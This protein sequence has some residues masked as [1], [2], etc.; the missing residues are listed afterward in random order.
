MRAAA[1][2]PAHRQADRQADLR[3]RRL[4]DESDRL[5][6]EVELLRLG[7]QRALPLPLRA[8]IERFQVRLG[9]SD[10]PL[11]PGSLRSAHEVVLALQQRLL[12]ANPRNPVP[13]SHPNRAYGQAL[14][15]TLEG[16]CRW[17]LLTL[18]ATGS[19]S[20][21]EWRLSVL[22]TLG[23]ALDRWAYAQHHAAAACRDRSGATAA[24]AR[25]RT[26]WVNYWELREEAERML[27]ELELAP[28]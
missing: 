20:P 9:R 21:D 2:R 10:A 23:R 17:K 26:A 24:M 16:G 14:T 13:R 8:E 5:L 7:N 19:L 11:S 6:D 4:L 22:A 18:P 25:A 12:A 3:R 1:D 28:L 15:R 27:G